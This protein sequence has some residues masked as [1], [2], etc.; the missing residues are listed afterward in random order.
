M[1]FNNMLVSSTKDVHTIAYT[2]GQK[3][4]TYL[5]TKKEI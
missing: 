3:P 5:T 1:A 2:K 4:R